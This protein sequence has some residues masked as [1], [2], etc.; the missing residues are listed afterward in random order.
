MI[1]TENM[2]AKEII[3][4]FK[5]NYG[6]VRKL[7][8]E[9]SKNDPENEPYASKY[10][11]KAILLNMYVSLPTISQ[12]Q[13]EDSIDKV[14]LDA[15]MGTV[16][17]NIGIIDMETEELTASE[18]VLVEAEKLLT[19]NATKPEV[20]RTLI[21]VYNHLGILWSNR[22]E[23]EKAK[24]YLVKAKDLYEN[25]KCTL[26]I[27]LAIE[28]IINNAG[29]T[30]ADDFL[31]FEKAHTLTLYYLAQVFWALKQNLKAAIYYYVTLRRQ[32]QYSDYEPIDWALNSA[33]LSQYFAEQ[34]GFF[35]SRHL[36]AA[37]ST[38]L[39]QHEQNL[40][41][42]ES[43][44]E[45]HLAKLE[46]FKHRSADVARCWAKYCLLLM[47]ASK[48]RLM[49]DAERLEDAITDMSNLNLEDTENICGGD[50]KNIN[51]PELDVSKYENKVTDKFLLMYQ[52]ARE[53]FLNCQSWLNKAKEYYKLDS[54]ASDYI[55]LTQ[56]SSQSYA[57]LAFFEEDDE[58]RAKMHKRRVDMLEEL[59][60]EI[61]PVYYLQ[62]CRQLWYELGEVYSEILNIK[63]D[64]V[65]KSSEKPS[66]HALKKIN[67]LCEKSIENYDHF[68][69]SIK[70]KNGKLPRKLE[71]DVIRPVVSAYA[72][73][74]RNS[75]KRIA[76]DK[77][78]QLS[79][80]KKSY[81]SYQ[82]VVDIC[83]SDEEAASMMKEEYS[84][85]KEMVQ[86]LPIKIKKLETELVS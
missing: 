53:V 26:Q 64:K 38:I 57:Y 11:A 58:R 47:S 14:K 40:Q 44:E 74:G 56:D 41:A 35:Q 33:T 54:L 10:K 73:M 60:K 46:T 45:A 68:L 77:S 19:P 62:Y 28:Q 67:M 85:C 34:N 82:A 15:M 72:Y 36:L 55:K 2:T 79:N 1:V 71:Y 23:Q 50:I 29:E 84:L 65:N 48:A 59:V 32:L 86:I 8:D 69:N 5:E 78:M 21:N 4:D 9:D 83:K 63:L 31:L 12:S 13:S 17:L 76:L 42:V 18:N 6:K 3:N 37:S 20:V 43:N 30:T 75:M 25:F 66:P 22:G 81:E 80:I 61:N 49:D 51:F 16:L 52:D 24:E 7:L 27:P 70:D 39:E